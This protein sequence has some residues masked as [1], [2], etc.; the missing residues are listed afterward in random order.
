MPDTRLR[1]AWT[2]GWRTYAALAAWSIAFGSATDALSLSY[3][4]AT[5][6]SSLSAAAVVYWIS[7]LLP[8][9]PHPER[10]T[11]STRTENANRWASSL[12][13]L[14]SIAGLAL[15]TLVDVLS[16]G[17]PL[18]P[19]SALALTASPA[20]AAATLWLGA[21]FSVDARSRG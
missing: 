16:R 5:A 2:W 19:S 8:V 6:S 9:R 12:S 14:L 7:F 3:L 18:P 4:A 1:R 11:L 20:L 10:K 21:Y 13:P 15:E 17:S